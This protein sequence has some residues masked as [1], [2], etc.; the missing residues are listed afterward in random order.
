MKAKVEALEFN[1]T[2][3]IV[4]VPPNVKPI[5]CKWV[6]KI[7]RHLDGSVERYKARLV[8]KGFAQTKGVNYFKT[9]S[10]VVKMATVRV[11]LALA[12]IHRW[13]IQQLDVNN[14]FLHGD[15]S[16]D[17]Y[18]TVPLGVS[19]SGTPKCCKLHK[20]LY[21]LKQYNR[22][23]YEKLSIP[24][25]SCGYQ[26]AQADHSLFVKTVDS[27]FTALIVYVDD[28]ILT[29][30]STDE[31]AHIKHVLH[32]NF[33]IKDLDILKYFLGIEVAHSETG[34]SIC[35]CKYCL[36]LIRD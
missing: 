27:S 36:D 31:M 5:G 2:W 35:Q 7:K 19:A 28:I 15:L 13:T 33:R 20:S 21:G 12:S 34:I 10:P 14:A 9:F 8:A 29:G 11:V 26:Q 24:L 18:M 23:W 25:L 1:H 22:K 17:V 16:E 6:Y 4:D 30:N 3:T 32:S